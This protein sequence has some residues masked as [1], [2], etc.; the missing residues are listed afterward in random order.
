MSRLP[1]HLS[2]AAVSTRA[3]LHGVFSA[4]RTAGPATT[5]ARQSIATK[6]ASI[7]ALAGPRIAVTEGRSRSA[8][9]GGSGRCAN[10]GIAQRRDPLPE[11]QKNTPDGAM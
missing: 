5:L 7:I 11:T 3:V 8:S 2:S 9:V 10:D 4:D 1:L 6:T